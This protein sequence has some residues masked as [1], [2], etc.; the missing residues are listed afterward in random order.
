MSESGH[1]HADKCDWRSAF[2]VTL[3]RAYPN[4]HLSALG[5]SRNP[6]DF[7]GMT[8][9]WRIAGLVLVLT[10]GA[11]ATTAPEVPLIAV[12]ASAADVIREFGPPK[13]KLTKNDQEVFVYATFEVTLRN[14]R[15]TKVTIKHPLPPPPNN[16]QSPLEAKVPA[17]TTQT[18][19]PTAPTNSAKEITP[20]TIMGV[21]IAMWPLYLILASLLPIAEIGR[22]L[23][24]RHR[25][26]KARA[27]QVLATSESQPPF[28]TSAGSTTGGFLTTTLNMGL[29][30]RLEW[31][32]FEQLVS[33]YFAAKGFRIEASNEAM[34][35]Q[36]RFHL[37]N[38]GETVPYAYLQCLTGENRDVEV[39]AVREFLGTLAAAHMA[40]GVTITSGDFTPEA[41]EFAAANDITAISGEELVAQ[42]HHLPAARQQDILMQV[43]TGDYTT[44]TCPKCNLKLELRGEG[45]FWGCVNWPKCRTKIFVRRAR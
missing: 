11:L 40:E 30:Q 33:L 19:S 38:E 39:K 5:L 26:D 23:L 32:R 43:T 15:V 4:E 12:G 27:N 24:K 28:T 7:R 17:A 25:R 16:V 21:L 6:D 10:L 14:H 1:G 18:L 20:I 9:I 37:F 2:R 3:I 36:T 35:K 31:K 8:R 44:P 13:S 45:T 41:R 42:F 34:E 22:R 29:L